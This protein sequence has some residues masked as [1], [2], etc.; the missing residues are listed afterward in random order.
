MARVNF[1][2][3][4][5]TPEGQRIAAWLA[6]QRNQSDAIRSLILADLDRDDDTMR[7]VRAVERVIDQRLA[8]LA[9]VQQNG[10]PKPRQED[11]QLA[12]KLDDMF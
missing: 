3:D 2:Y 8:G 7:L 9:L 12:Q 1:R 6:R 4:E 11:P 10:Q 5:T